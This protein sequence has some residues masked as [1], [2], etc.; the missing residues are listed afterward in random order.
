MLQIMKVLYCTVR[1]SDGL[2]NAQ[3]CYKCLEMLLKHFFEIVIKMAKLV[4]Q[5]NAE[6]Q[7][8]KVLYCRVRVSDGL[9]AGKKPSSSGTTQSS[10]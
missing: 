3:K 7:I 2:K 9:G 4:S 1:V 8:M 5:V 6:L 10:Q